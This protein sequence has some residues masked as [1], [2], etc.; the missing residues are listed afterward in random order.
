[1]PLTISVTDSLKKSVEAASGGRVTVMYTA[2]GQASYMAVIPQFNVQ[3][4]DPAMGTGVHP[5]FIVGGVTKPYRYI[6]LYPGVIRNG[7]LL[8]LPGEDPANSMNFDSGLATARANGA[9]WGLMTNVDWAGIGQLCYKS[10]FQ[11]RGN[12]DYGRSSDLTTERG[13]D[14]ITGLIAAATGTATSRTRTGSGPVSWRHDATAFGISDLTGNV[15]EWSPGMR[16]N[17]GELQI[18]ANNDA[19]LVATDMTAASA[20][21]KAIDGSTGALVAPGSVG[22]VKYAQSGSAD[23]T[24]VRASGASFDGITNPGANPVS[25]A[26][27]QLLKQHGLYPVANTGLGSDGIWTTLTGE[28]LPIRGGAWGNAATSGVF[29]LVLSNVRAGTG[30]NIGCRPAFVI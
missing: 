11:P 3:D 20:A 14:S 25:V 19:A 30:T 12:T 5:M 23:Y 9:G 18:I 6:G 22:T 8:S 2:K 29:A 1:M 13:V 10:G 24:L 4:I 16:L 21:W 27:I 15:W 7:E 17:N 28:M 26:A